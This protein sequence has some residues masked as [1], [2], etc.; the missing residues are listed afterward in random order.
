MRPPQ[1][2]DIKQRRKISD[3]AFTSKKDKGSGTEQEFRRLPSDILMEIVYSNGPRL[4]R[5]AARTI[6]L[7]RGYDVPDPFTEKQP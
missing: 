6:L 7:E 1:H 5:L 2:P 3:A 4:D